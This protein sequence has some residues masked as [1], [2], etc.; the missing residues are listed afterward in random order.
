MLDHH[1]LTKLQPTAVHQARSELLRRLREKIPT[2][3]EE[4]LQ[5]YPAVQEH[6]EW[7]LELIYTDYVV[8]ERRGEAVTVEAYCARF[9][10][11][12]DRIQR[13][14]RVGELLRD[15]AVPASVT[16]LQPERS[17]VTQPDLEVSSP[18]GWVDR[19]ELLDRLGVGGMGV[20][21]LAYQ[22]GL[23]RLVAL[24]MMRK[25]D[26]S[27]AEDYHRFRH[28]AESMAL[29]HHPNI[30]S[31]YAVGERDGLPYF[32][33]EYVEG[34][35]LAEQIDGQPVDTARAVQWV[36]AI[37]RAVHFAHC[38]GIVHRDL[39]PSNI[40]L[41]VDLVPKV[42]DFGLVKF[43][44]RSGFT[45]TGAVLGTPCYIPP[46]QAAGRKAEVGPRS[47]VYALG[48]ILYELLT[49][50]M[51][52]EG[53]TTHEVLRKVQTE[54]VVP[55]RSLNPAV[56]RSLEAICLK[57]LAKRPKDRYASAEAVADD[58]A[59][60]RRC[61]E[62]VALPPWPK[63]IARAC[64]APAT[65][66][67]LG[68]LLL[69]AMTVA[70]VVHA[71]DPVR[72]LEAGQEELQRGW[73][74]RVYS[75]KGSLP[76]H[77]MVAASSD[78]GILQEPEGGFTVSASGRC[79]M[80]ILPDPMRPAYVFR[81]NVRHN[82]AFERY[83]R[84]G[85]YC[86]RGEQ[87]ISPPDTIFSYCY[88]TFNEWMTVD[89]LFPQRTKF[90]AEDAET[91]HAHLGQHHFSRAEGKPLSQLPHTQLNFPQ[92]HGPDFAPPRKRHHLFH[93]LEL[94]VTPAGVE[95]SWDGKRFPML[96]ADWLVR[97]QA[98]AFRE[99][100]AE[101]FPQYTPRGGLGLYVDRASATFTDIVVEP[102]SPGP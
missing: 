20:V 26:E 1:S 73:P 3:V 102:D 79:L 27:T 94:R 21:F 63:R 6:A 4:I 59:R 65:L 66:G 42:G 58:L 2:K 31:V 75:H 45:R 77:Q 48:A 12:Q 76:W 9:P 78:V 49:G 18:L 74:F 81:A 13:I 15:P 51:P 28:E 7:A 89:R 61:E 36:E 14:M 82:D 96:P 60:L 64:L 93:T 62:T 29:L 25:G 80:E 88:L 100:L 50:Q 83:A 91:C 11:W 57:C 38:R 33:M 71:R 55:P 16:V 70:T 72:K 41:T 40:L 56:E 98:T 32:A 101:Y 23:N 39:K 19:F 8:R 10:Q 37:A 85:L 46:E 22:A 92:T 86:A 95:A 99:R 97:R 67:C 17:A 69:T 52:F 35:S 68:L 43:Q 30:V 34:G 5:A 54:S 87:D 44:D 84:V 53:E 24:K 90:S 47:D